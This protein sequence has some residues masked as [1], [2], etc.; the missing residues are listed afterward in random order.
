[1]FV[2][3]KVENWIILI[4]TKNIGLTSLPTSALG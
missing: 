2:P 1:M 4:D 3:G